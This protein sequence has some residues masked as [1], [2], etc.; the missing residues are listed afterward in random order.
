[1][2]GFARVTHPAQGP[3]LLHLSIACTLVALAAGVAFA[4]GARAEPNVVMIVTDDQRTTGTMDIADPALDPMAKTKQWFEAGGTRFPQGSTSTP[5]C[6]PSRASIF[7]GRYVHNHNVKLITDA[8][9]LG[10]TEAPTLPNGQPNPQRTTLQY[11]LQQQK[12]YRTGLFGKYLNGWDA[13]CHTSAPPT[14]PPFFTKYALLNNSYSPSCVNEQGTEKWMW[15]YTTD[16][17]A[18]KAEQFIQQA[19]DESPNQPWFLYVAPFAPHAPF[20]PAPQYA[21]AAVPTFAHSGSRFEADRSDK[22]TFYQS[23]FDMDLI[24]KQ[25]SDQLRMLRSI[26]DLVEKVMQKVNAVGD[27]NNTIAFYTSDNG[28]MW[29][30]HGVAAKSKPYLDAVKVPFYLRWPGWAGHAGGETDNR[31]VGSVD[32]APTIL[33]AVGGV[34]PSVPLDGQSLLDSADKR[35]RTLT[36]FWQAGGSSGKYLS[37]AAIRTPTFH[38]IEHYLVPNTALN[39][40]RTCI[41]PSSCRRDAE[42]Y[43][44]IADP[45]EETNL[46]VDGD[47]KNNPPTGILSGQID[48]DYDCPNGQSCPGPGEADVLAPD[49]A[50]TSGPDPVSGRDVTFTFTKSEPA[51]G[52]ACY[53]D[54]GAWNACNQTQTYTNLAPGPHS[55]SVMGIGPGLQFMD[56]TPATWS[57][58]VDDSIPD[59]RLTGTPPDTTK[60][61]NSRDPTFTWTSSNATAFECTLDTQSP[62]ACTS[63][64][65]YSN[66]TDGNHTFTVKAISGSS[67]DQTPPTHTWKIDATPP[68]TALCPVNGPACIAE[69]ATTH[70]PNATFWFRTEPAGDQNRFECQLD[71][72]PWRWCY[73]DISPTGV[74]K[75]PVRWPLPEAERPTR[76]SVRGYTPSACAPSTRPT[77][78]TRLPRPAHGRSARFRPSTPRRI[79]D[80]RPSRAAPR[81]ARSSRTIAAAGT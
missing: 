68:T 6:C 73:S 63:P 31:L 17:L 50:I 81:C 4:P 62:S 9:V 26:D 44:L 55:L 47:P 53:L 49:T 52:F 59:A 70:S 12:G 14:P 37:F 19:H 34:T 74:S 5:L 67:G 2:P 72:G 29:G 79:R 35:N 15:R 48:S 8:G 33:D 58:T 24:A 42:Y 27:G 3:R 39:P 64:K 41:P 16:Y 56:I 75:L 38:Y 69:G 11:Y 10:T 7:T 30:E 40:P 45:H 65:S 36:E 22:P 23:P 13:N 18:E 66:L 51:G 78:P 61:S 32:F 25:S 21:G 20:T 77:T 57:W 80:G 1:M 71:S 46:L 76:G 43:N 28:Y 54:N 60:T